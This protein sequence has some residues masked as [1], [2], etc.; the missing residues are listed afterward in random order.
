MDN[1]QAVRFK[2]QVI[3]QVII[4]FPNIRILNQ[5]DFPHSKFHTYELIVHILIIRSGGFFQFRLA[6]EI[7]IK[8]I[9]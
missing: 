9:I 6:T 4:K 2:T 5:A 8:N 3:D 1:L 7:D